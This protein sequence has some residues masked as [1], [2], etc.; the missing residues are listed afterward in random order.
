[1]GVLNIKDQGAMKNSGPM[2]LKQNSD[3]NF[4]SNAESYYFQH[5]HN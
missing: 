4:S 1:M 5:S 2:L 3:L